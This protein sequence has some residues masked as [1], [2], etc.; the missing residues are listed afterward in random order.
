M[1]RCLT[2]VIRMT[3]SL[4]TSFLSQGLSYET[5]LLSLLWCP[6]RVSFGTVTCLREV[7]TWTSFPFTSTFGS[8]EV[9]LSPVTTRKKKKKDF[10]VNQITILRIDPCLKCIHINIRRY[11]KF[12]DLLRDS[13]LNQIVVD[14]HRFN[15][16]LIRNRDLQKDFRRSQNLSLLDY[17]YDPT[18]MDFSLIENL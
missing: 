5:S 10:Y 17:L 2:V 1:S 8:R 7:L 13:I 11:V 4:V 15:N 6:F 9:S 14:K 18:T 3:R 12:R 16:L